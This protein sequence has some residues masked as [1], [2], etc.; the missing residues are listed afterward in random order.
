MNGFRLFTLEERE[1]TANIV[2]DVLAA[3]ERVIGFQRVGSGV[4]DGGDRHADVDYAVVIERRAVPRE[5]ARDAAGRMEQLLP[6]VG[7]YDVPF[8]EL[9]V[10]SFLLENALEVDLIIGHDHALAR[11]FPEWPRS[12][13]EPT[14]RGRRLVEFVWHDV[15]HAATALVRGRLWRSLY[16]VERVGDAALELAALRHGLEAA[17]FRE[18]DDLGDDELAPLAATLVGRLERAELAAALRTATGSFFAAARRLDASLPG[19]LEETLASY[20]DAVLAPYEPGSSR[21]PSDSRR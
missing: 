4:G 18:I 21:V 17:H 8:D 7:H 10:A 20:L 9:R 12:T 11:F 2:E 5:V 14:E 19:R 6:V 3:D 15:T 1:E 16:H 13:G